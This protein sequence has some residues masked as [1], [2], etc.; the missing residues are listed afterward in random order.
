MRGLLEYDVW[1]VEVEMD[2]GKQNKLFLGSPASR[3]LPV[4]VHS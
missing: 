2:D 3:R 4:A 1:C